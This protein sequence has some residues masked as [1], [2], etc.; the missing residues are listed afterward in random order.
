MPTTTVELSGTQTRPLGVAGETVAG[1]QR[2]LKDTLT[3]AMEPRR[4]GGGGAGRAYRLLACPSPV[5]SFVTWIRFTRTH[6]HGV[7]K[8]QDGGQNGHT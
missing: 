6:S 2:E 7:T 8:L 3:S 5:D 1:R 4:T